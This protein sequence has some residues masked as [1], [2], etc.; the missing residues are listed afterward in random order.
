MHNVSLDQT[1]WDRILDAY[2]NDDNTNGASI[3]EWVLKRFACAGVYREER[4]YIRISFKTREQ[5]VLFVL[6]HG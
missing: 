2:F 5:A 6:K 3:K 4:G 1:Q